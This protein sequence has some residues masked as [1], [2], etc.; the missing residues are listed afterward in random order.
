M[1]SISLQIVL[2]TLK[3]GRTPLH[4]ICCNPSVTS[5]VIEILFDAWPGAAMVADQELKLPVQYLVDNPVSSS[6]LS[7]LLIS[8]PSSYRLRY[9]FLSVASPC[10]S[11]EVDSEVVYVQTNLAIDSKSASRVAMRFFST[12]QTAEHEREMLLQLR[13]TVR[14]CLSV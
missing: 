9:D 14:L 2:Q 11:Y 3:D 7:A 12:A 13:R 6:D 4:H 8:G 1:C 10:A 5:V